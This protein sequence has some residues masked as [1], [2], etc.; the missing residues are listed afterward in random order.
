M[1]KKLLIATTILFVSCAKEKSKKSYF[2]FYQSTPSIVPIKIYVDR[3]FIGEVDDIVIHKINSCEKL[4]GMAKTEVEPNNVYEIIY[5]L[6]PI[7][8]TEY[9]NIGENECSIIEIE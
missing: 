5:Q 7:S 9:V 3:S 4:K 1:I 8:D 2:L 6:G